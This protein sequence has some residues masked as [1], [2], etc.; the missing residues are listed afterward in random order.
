MLRI[1][2]VRNSKE[3]GS[4]QLPVLTI[5]FWH[6][7]RYLVILFASVLA[8]GAL[9]PGDT[10]PAKTI[11]VLS[12]YFVGLSINRIPQLDNNIPILSKETSIMLAA[13]MASAKSPTQTRT[14][15]RQRDRDPQVHPFLTFVM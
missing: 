7:G 11:D 3:D 5:A 4:I 6:L 9:R 10:A 14:R 13:P 12:K 2:Y 1:G 15:R 8:H